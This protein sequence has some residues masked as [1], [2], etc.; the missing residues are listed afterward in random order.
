MEKLGAVRV[1]SIGDYED[2]FYIE[3][4]S[5]WNSDEP[6]WAVP[7]W[8]ERGMPHFCGPFASSEAAQIAL[9]DGA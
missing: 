8:D 1:S 6:Q 5:Y 7:A 9:A 3:Q 2:G 4:F